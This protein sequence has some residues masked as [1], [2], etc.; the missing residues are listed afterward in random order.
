M[1]GGNDDRNRFRDSDNQHS[2]PS[3]LGSP[4]LST[5]RNH[6]LSA[7]IEKGAAARLPF[8]LPLYRLFLTEYS[9]F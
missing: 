7:P 8:R 2:N 5:Q 1:A 4:A 9:C 3:I 6:L